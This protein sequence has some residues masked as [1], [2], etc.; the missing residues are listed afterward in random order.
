MFTF[1]ALF[2]CLI[3]LHSDESR[4]SM[5]SYI[6]WLEVLFLGGMGMWQARY[7]ALLLFNNIVIFYAFK[8]LFSHLNQQLEEL[9]KH[10]SRYGPLLSLSALRLCRSYLNVHRTLVDILIRADQQMLSYM[11][12]YYFYCSMPFSLTATIYLLL[13]R[14]RSFDEQLLLQALL[15]V[16]MVGTAFIVATMF[17]CSTHLHASGKY[18]VRLQYHLADPWMLKV[19]IRWMT[20]HERIHLAYHHQPIGVQVQGA[21]VISKNNCLL[22]L[23]N[24][25]LGYLLIAFRFFNHN[26]L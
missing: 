7:V 13:G 20:Y 17:P 3:V 25:Y 1:S 9:C 14:F 23:L 11:M 21:G 10:L 6:T 4:N 16:Q 5:L 18:F 2:F 12:T 8:C 22:F 24:F 15:L 26:L 19:K